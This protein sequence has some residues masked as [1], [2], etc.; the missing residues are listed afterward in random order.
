MK[1]LFDASDL[2]ETID[3]INQLS[4]ETKG[5]WGKMTVDQMLAHVNVAYEMA[6]ED[7]HKKPNFLMKLLL[8]TFVKSAVVNEKPY[9][10]NSRTA[11]AFIVK[12]DKDFAKEKQRLIDYLRKTQDLG[13]VHFEGK[14]SP[15]FGPLTTTE[16]NNLFSKHLDHH[17]TQFGV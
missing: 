6:Y 5:Q 15:S 11:P 3:R 10:R 12:G 2:E 16:W 8:K 1:N 13:A 17:L 4:S 9:P 7:K 14:E